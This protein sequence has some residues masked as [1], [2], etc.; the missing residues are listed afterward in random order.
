MLLLYKLYGI[1]AVAIAEKTKTK[2]KQKTKKQK[3]KNKNRT[4]QN[5]TTPF[6]NSVEFAYMGVRVLTSKHGWRAAP[7]N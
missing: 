6:S 1:I 4:K 5:K 3:T 2:Q 7:K